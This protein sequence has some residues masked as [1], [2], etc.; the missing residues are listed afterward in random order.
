MRKLFYLF[1]LFTSFQVTKA[2]TLAADLATTVP[3]YEAEGKFV[4]IQGKTP[5]SY[6]YGVAYYDEA[7][8]Y[9][10][11]M[12]GMFDVKD[13]KLV[14]QEAAANNNGFYIVRINNPGLPVTLL[15]DSQLDELKADKDMGWLKSYR[16][17]APAEEQLLERMSTLNGAGLSDKAL[18][19]LQKLYQ[20]QYHNAKLFFELIFAYNALGKVAEAEKTADEAM[21]LGYNDELIIKEKHFAMLF[22]KKLTE[23]GDFLKKNLDNVK[24][25]T[26]KKELMLNQISQ[27]NSNKD[28]AKTQEWI[29]LYRNIHGADQYANALKKM[30]D[31]L[32]SK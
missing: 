13:Q 20:Q 11:R 2:Q 1:I 32:N 9:T 4:A 23:A 3:F 8:L 27:F 10:F 17:S 12:L 30:E 5:G 19:N 16:T 28:K 24:N 14:P 18:P 29:N 26:Y 22:G 21:K 15:K 25:P 31:G 7:A 6:V